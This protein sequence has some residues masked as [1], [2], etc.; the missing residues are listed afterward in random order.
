MTLCLCKYQA[1]PTPKRVARE[2]KDLK[3]VKFKASPLVDPNDKPSCVRDN[4]LAPAAVFTFCI[5]VVMMSTQGNGYV[6]TQEMAGKAVDDSGL[7]MPKIF[8]QYA[9][10]MHAVMHT[11]ASSLVL[12]IDCNDPVQLGLMD[13]HPPKIKS[14]DGG[15]TNINEAAPVVLTSDD[16]ATFLQGLAT[17]PSVTSS[18]E[19]LGVG[20]YGY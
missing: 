2:R 16:W 20:C 17:H 4:L 14:V 15:P 12:I 1:Q 18:K 3:I 5:A 13:E 7:V 11:L 9:S 19:P 10:W 8:G 6:L